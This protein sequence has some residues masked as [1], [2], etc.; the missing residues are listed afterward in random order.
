MKVLEVLLVL[1]Y[2]LVLLAGA[3][4]MIVTYDWSAW[5]LLIPLVFGATWKDEK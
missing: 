1:L 2:N 5:C 4:Y 3:C